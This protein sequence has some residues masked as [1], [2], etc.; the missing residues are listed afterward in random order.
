[1]EKPVYIDMKDI[2]KVLTYGDNEDGDVIMIE[3]DEEEREEGEIIEMEASQRRDISEDLPVA[4]VLMAV[5]ALSSIIHRL[6]RDGCQGCRD[7]E[8]GQEG[9]Q[10]CLYMEWPEK[11]DIYFEGALKQL[12]ERDF[13]HFLWS[14]YNM[15][16][17]FE[18]DR[19]V[20]MA[21]A[22]EFFHFNLKDEQVKEFI[23]AKMMRL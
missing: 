14:V 4:P 3:D 23:K 7:D 15:P 11:V 2:K 10:G 12:H 20:A 9:H 8:P 19:E 5:K 22:V 13:L 18:E 17:M 16:I 21:E 6:V 1:M